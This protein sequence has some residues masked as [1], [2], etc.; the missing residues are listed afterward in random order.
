[1][2]WAT[3]LVGKARQVRD[4]D[5]AAEEPCFVSRWRGAIRGFSQGASRSLGGLGAQ[6]WR[7]KN[8]FGSY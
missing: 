3:R 2:W 5:Y 4:L 1:M 6:D 7:L 8:Q